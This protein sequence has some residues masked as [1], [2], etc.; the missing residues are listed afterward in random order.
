MR[1]G[2]TLSDR[3]W[4]RL[5]TV[6]ATDD[7]TGKLQAAWL[8]K[9]QLWT[10][11]GTGFLADTDTAKDRP[12]VLVK[13]SRQPETTRLWRTVC[14]WWK[15]IKVLSVIGATTTKVEANN[16]VINTS[17]GQAG[18]SP[19]PQL[20]KRVSCCAVPSVQRHEH[21]SWQSIHHESRIASKA[22][23]VRRQIAFLV[24]VQPA[25]RN[26]ASLSVAAGASSLHMVRLDCPNAESS[27]SLLS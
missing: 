27:S 7:A 24:A 4:D 10:L 18:D 19:T 15:E 3:A 23:S 8:V 14:R 16:T 5:N 9:E 2:D 11:L 26:Y 6:F 22:R 1:A 13:Q 25:P 21:S 12:Q 17:K 20:Q